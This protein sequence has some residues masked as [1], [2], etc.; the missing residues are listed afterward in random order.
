MKL[1]CAL[2]CYKVCAITVSM[3]VCI[4]NEIW[5]PKSEATGMVDDK[6][7]DE[8]ASTDDDLPTHSVELPST[9][10]APA[11]DTLNDDPVPLGSELSD[12]Q[13]ADMVVQLRNLIA[14]NDNA[15]CHNTKQCARLHRRGAARGEGK[16]YWLLRCVVLIRCSLVESS[17]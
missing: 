16:C 13:V 1:V 8:Y 6:S 12:I 7:R 3:H 2:A 9:D 11:F 4:R 17:L 5:L 10:K 14:T 15:H